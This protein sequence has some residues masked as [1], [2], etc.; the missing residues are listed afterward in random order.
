M[1]LRGNTSIGQVRGAG[2]DA[3]GNRRAASLRRRLRAGFTLIELLVVI[4]I[5]AILAA[6]IFPVFSTLRENSRESDTMAH[7]HDISAALALYKLD[8]H[9]YPPVLFAYACDSNANAIDKCSTSDTMATI[10]GDAAATNELVGLYPE[11]VRDWHAFTCLNDPVNDNGGANITG[12]VNG[13]SGAEPQPNYLQPDGALMRANGSTTAPYR[14]FFTADAFDLSPE[15]SAP[16]QLATGSYNNLTYI[17]RYQT[18]WTSW[19]NAYDPTSLVAAPDQTEDTTPFQ[20]TNYA[21]QLAWQNPP[22][23]TFITGVT[24]HVQNANRLI[25]LYADGS[26]HKK[27]MQLGPWTA[28]WDEAGR[29]QTAAN[30]NPTGG[31]YN[32]ATVGPNAESATN[33][34]CNYVPAG[35][36]QYDYTK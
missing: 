14:A 34:Y 2:K 13:N 12:T 33:P 24:D 10:G 32:N 1:I 30:I 19:D 11:Y 3:C 36:W 23:N 7:L 6:I 29:N 21:R 20:D 17:I 5:I 16:N 28:G 26:A 15:V 31:T 25:V 9:K 27:T 35:F 18:S 8:N 22:A 4:A